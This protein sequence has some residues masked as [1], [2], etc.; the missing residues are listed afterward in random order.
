MKTFYHVTLKSLE[1][2]IMEEGLLPKIGERSS[3]IKE[4]TPAVYLFK[5]REGLEN[6]LMNWL[7]EELP[8]DEE[9]LYLEVT[10]PEEFINSDPNSFEIRCFDPIPTKYLKIISI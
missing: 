3:L 10:L 7:G 5:T 1:A 6:A 4:K 9:L 2:K 8:E